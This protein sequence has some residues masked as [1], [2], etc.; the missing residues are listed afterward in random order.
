VR[1]DRSTASGIAIMDRRVVAYPDVEADEMPATSR[2]GCLALGTLSMVFVPM[3]SEGRAIGTMWVGRK[4][5]GPFSDKQLA[6]LKT[7]AEQAVIA[8]QNARMFNDTRD[9]L[10]Q[11][12]ASGEVLAAISSSIADVGPVFDVILGNCQQLF[13]AR[14][15]GIT[16]VRDDGM[17]DVAA[18]VGPGREALKR[19]FPR[20]LGRDVAA[21]VAILDR[22]MYAF[23]DL[24]APDVPAVL[25]AGSASLGDR[26]FLVSP[27]MLGDRAIGALWIGRDF[28]GDFAPKQLALLKT[29]TGQAV[30]ALQ[31]S[32]LF[33]ET[34]EAL[35]QQKA[36]GEVLAA[37]SS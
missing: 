7:F 25:R 22:K 26:S 10:E 35:E 3:L 28:K 33:N 5:K 23:P 16:L 18:H 11:Q 29:F 4:F 21:G 15:A 24:D 20:P 30:V 9:A 13:S 12:K 34:R 1:V 17:V 8:I 31:N 27:M 32:R 36:S 2:A 37:I 14:N 6:L 19:L